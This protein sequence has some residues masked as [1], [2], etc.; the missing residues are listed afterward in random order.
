MR[1][2]SS[3]H[4]RYFVTNLKSIFLFLILCSGTLNSSSY[5]QTH[6]CLCHK[7]YAA[8]TNDPDIWVYEVTY[9]VFSGDDCTS[10]QVYSFQ[11]E[12]TAGKE[13]PEYCEQC[14]RCGGTGTTSGQP[15]EDLSANPQRKPANRVARNANVTRNANAKNKV[16]DEFIVKISKPAG[17]E[18]FYLQ[19]VSKKYQGIEIVTSR[20]G[21]QIEEPAH[22]S[23]RARLIRY[24][25]QEFEGLVSRGNMGKI[26]LPNNLGEAEINY[27]QV[28]NDRYAVRIFE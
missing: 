18:W 17:A 25:N 9:H 23:A 7:E 6:Y 20:T 4:E 24:D 2:I 14:T 19:V 26:T 21:Y 3:L 13:L 5:A 28:G 27:V 12:D 22:G 16:T 15:C 1:L 8:D 10:G 11:F